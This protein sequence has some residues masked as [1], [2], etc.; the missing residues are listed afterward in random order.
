ML[1]PLFM[2]QQI[3]PAQRKAG[4]LDIHNRFARAAALRDDGQPPDGV[5]G[6][7]R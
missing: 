4:A 6:G 3:A 2:D 5:M 7:N 1:W